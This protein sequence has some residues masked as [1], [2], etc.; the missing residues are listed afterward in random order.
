MPAP[1]AV[2]SS[3]ARPSHI[4]VFSLFN[5][6]C[7]VDHLCAR[8]T[9][10]D[11]AHRRSSVCMSRYQYFSLVKGGPYRP[12]TINT[13]ICMVDQAT[14]FHR[15]CLIQT[16][17]AKPAESVQAIS[18]LRQAFCSQCQGCGL[19]GFPVSVRRRGM[20]A[21]LTACLS[22]RDSLPGGCGSLPPDHTYWT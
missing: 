2:H 4:S 20:W 1:G 12:H 13:A 10:T 5:V 8:R 18:P 15:G 14:L 16:A 11:Y 3:L 7:Q 9:D 21:V 17:D 6:W 19:G 22:R